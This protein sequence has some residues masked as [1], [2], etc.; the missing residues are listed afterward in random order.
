MYPSLG[1]SAALVVPAAP[2]PRDTAPNTSGPAP[3]VIALKA[4]A[5]G[6]VRIV[7]SIPTK[8]TVTNTHF[9]IENVVFL[10]MGAQISGI[11]LGVHDDDLSAG[12]AVWLGLLMTAI[13][14]A[15]RLAFPPESPYSRSGSG[16]LGE[17]GGMHSARTDRQAIP[18]VDH[19]DCDRKVGNFL[20]GKLLACR[21][22]IVLSKRSADPGGDDAALRLAGIGHGIAHEVYAASLPSGS[23]DLGDGRL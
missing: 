18:G 1:L 20:F 16:R 19:R 21:L 5:T 10:L 9:V 12:E 6:T 3:R 4:D 13:L 22:G 15:L 23:Q 11:I 7:G 2:V 17:I 14:L 8:I